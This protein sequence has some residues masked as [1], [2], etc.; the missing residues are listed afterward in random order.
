MRLLFSAVLALS[1]INPSVTS[2]NPSPPPPPTKR[3]HVVEMHGHRLV[4][5]F[6]WMRERENPEVVKHLEAEN[7]YAEAFLAPTKALQETLYNEILGRIQQSDLS[8]PYRDRG[9]WYYTRTV[10][11]QP[12]PICCR[13][14]GTLDAPEEVLL[15]VNALAKDFPNINAAPAAISPDNRIMAYAV[16]PTGGR[17]NTIKFRDLSTGQD[18]PDQLENAAGDV[19]FGGDSQ[20]VFFSTLDP[21]IRSDKAWRYV[22]GSPDQGQKPQL[23][24]HEEDEK[25]FVG[26]G[27]SQ[28]DS[29][30]F[31]TLYSMK[32][33]EAW[34]LPANEP[35][36]QFRV[37]APRKQGVQYSVDYH[38]GRFFI[39]HNE[40]ALNFRVDTAPVESPGRENW[41]PFI[42]HNP[43]VYIQGLLTLKDHLVIAARENGLPVLR[44][45]GYAQ[46]DAGRVITMPEPSYDLGLGSNAEY[47]TDT[48]RFTYTSPVTPPSVFDENLKTGER[49][50][51]KEQPVLGGYDRT[52]Y[53]VERL[54]APARD[55]QTIPLTIVY[56]KGLK[57][58]SSNPTLLYGYGSYG[59][60]EDP[61]FR[62]GSISLLDRGWVLATAQIR[63]GADKGRGWY[64]DGRLMNKKNTFHDFIDCAEHLV[65]TSWTTPGKLAIEGGSAG[66]LLV[67]AVA[68][69]RPDLFRAIIAQVPFVDMM[70]T[71]LDPDL[72]LTVIEYEQW[73]NPAEKPAF[74]YML[75]YSPYDNVKPQAYP[76]VLVRTGFHDSNV[77]YWEGAKWA[78]K[79][80]ESSTSGEPILLLTNMDA[81]H[82]GFS[83]RYKA[84]RE[85]AEDFAFLIQAMGR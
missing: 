17:V 63:G 13:K 81:G 84:I 68:N 44:V 49:K 59:A 35:A 45:R 16:D 51:L 3:E 77:P 4:D 54:M 52:Q 28:D 10:E 38:A 57:P 76:R 72:P 82:G 70:N 12:H 5:P 36:G 37:V 78:A 6:F 48:V 20:T 39:T 47:D 60:T 33:T 55:G 15:D 40:N 53:A 71:M 2:A 65:K 79:L 9:Y 80:R 18:L 66:G 24:R 42:A 56:R 61:S 7:A 64:E 58:D 25:Y 26:L 19:V 29:I 30:I 1:M 67:G 83:D 27:Q 32:T 8:V 50:L 34:F 23:I 22:L 62:A 43:D 31:L 14:K 69:M 74:D 21:A 46:S 41:T 73:G 85:R 11:G 75:S